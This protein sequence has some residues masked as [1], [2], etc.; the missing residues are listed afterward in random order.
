MERR[1]FVS[2][3]HMIIVEQQYLACYSAVK[4][5]A[6]SFR[7]RGYSYLAHP[8]DDG[9][10]LCHACATPAHPS[11]V[12]RLCQPNTKKLH[13][14]L[15]RN[16]RDNVTFFVFCS[17]VC[18]VLTLCCHKGTFLELCPHQSSIASN[19]AM[20]GVKSNDERQADATDDHL[21]KPTEGTPRTRKHIMII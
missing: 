8:I 18:L 5:N 12:R 21:N 4:T 13:T 20:I 2:Q 3:L 17:S 19:V 9:S 1:R 15:T 14:C 11:F 7:M 10:A 16:T 6:T